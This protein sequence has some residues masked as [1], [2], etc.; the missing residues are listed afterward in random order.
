MLIALRARSSG[1]GRCCRIS[2][3]SVK[4]NIRKWY[5]WNC[6]DIDLSLT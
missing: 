2:F 5:G 1:I 4:T 3:E 6:F